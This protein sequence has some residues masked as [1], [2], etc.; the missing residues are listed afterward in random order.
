QCLKLFVTP[1]V[2][3]KGGPANATMVLYQ[4]IYNQ[5]FLN[6]EMGYA[7][8]IAFVLTALVLAFSLLNLKLSKEAQ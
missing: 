2:L 1:N 8:S 3:T 5:A 4:Y 7:A 6:F